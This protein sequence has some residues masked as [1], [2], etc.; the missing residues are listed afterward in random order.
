MDRRGDVPAPDHRLL[1]H[2]G[3]PLQ[4]DRTKVSGRIPASFESRHCYIIYR[5]LSTLPDTQE[6]GA[7][8]AVCAAAHPTPLSLPGGLRTT[9]ESGS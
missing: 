9:R 8:S 6:I 4:T 2:S 5:T 1:P 7:G 3:P